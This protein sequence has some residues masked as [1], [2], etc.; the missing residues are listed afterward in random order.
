MT[1]GESRI[2][3]SPSIGRMSRTATALMPA[4][5]GPPWSRIRA[6]GDGEEKFRLSEPVVLLCVFIK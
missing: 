5:G 6:A 2:S 3:R 1:R 4:V